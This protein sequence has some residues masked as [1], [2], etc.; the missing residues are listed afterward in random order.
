M[1]LLQNDIKNLK[2]GAV[3]FLYIF[4]NPDVKGLSA[5]ILRKR[6]DQINQLKKM[7]E[8]NAGYSFQ[9]LVNIVQM[10]IAERYGKTPGQML[11]TI[12]NAAAVPS[13]AKV[14]SIDGEQPSAT[15]LEAEEKVKN[16]SMTV[17]DEGETTKEK[18]VWTDIVSVIDWLIAVVQKL[19]GRYTD[20]KV[21]SPNHPDWTGANAPTWD[22]YDSGTSN[23]SSMLPILAVGGVLFYMMKNGGIKPLNPKLKKKK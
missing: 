11:Q 1:A 15:I 4:I 10:G 22:T 16:L 14:G 2:K 5:D 23:A 21:Y 12:Y 7:V 8:Y 3:N 6:N 17:S 20:P 9:N 19:F 13:Y 18:N